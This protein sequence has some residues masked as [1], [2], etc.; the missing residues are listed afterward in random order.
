MENPSYALRAPS[1]QG[2]KTR[3]RLDL[4]NNAMAAVL[5]PPSPLGEKCRAKR[6]DEGFPPT[7][8]ALHQVISEERGTRDRWINWRVHAI[9]N[10]SS[11]LQAPSP[12]GEKTRSRLDLNNNAMAAV[13]A[14]PS[15]PGEKGRAQRGDEGFPAM[16]DKTD[17]WIR[18]SGATPR[19]RNLRKNETD[20]EYRLWIEVRSRRLNGYK[21]ARQIPLGPYFVDF[22]CREKNLIV[23][24]DG[25]QHADNEHD[26]ARTEWLN[27]QGYSVLRFWNDEI[28]RERRA[29]LETILSVLE[30]RGATARFSPGYATAISTNE[31]IKP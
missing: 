11:A 2:E 10:P 3:L 24:L 6:G 7:G 17:A 21:F 30:G 4:N 1:P 14:P 20:A 26:I 27:V 19:A 12:Q 16:G 25:S 29:V 22:I 31:E 8:N 15:P 28:L 5:A 13:L 18:K 23:E 9:E